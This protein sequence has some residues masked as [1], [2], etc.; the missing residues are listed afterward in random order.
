MS[1]T[2]APRQITS[3]SAIE[4]PGRR[5][6]TVRPTTL[7]IA[8]SLLGLAGTVAY[9]TFDD[10]RSSSPAS[11]TSVSDTSVTPER[12]SP[13]GGP[14]D[15]K[16]GAAG[17]ARVSPLGGPADEKGAPVGSVH[18]DGPARPL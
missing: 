5:R 16:G 4:R 11:N 15:D 3:P 18:R 17:G 8:V 14:A 7:V 13:L 10:P 9:R 12:L 2:V 6:R 1:E